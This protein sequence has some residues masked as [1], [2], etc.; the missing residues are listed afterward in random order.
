M[1][2][3]KDSKKFPYILQFLICLEQLKLYLN[4]ECVDL[5]SDEDYNLMKEIPTKLFDKI[6]MLSHFND[7]L[8]ESK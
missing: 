7:K 8:I 3:D 2:V 1:I 4:T 6:K 5:Y